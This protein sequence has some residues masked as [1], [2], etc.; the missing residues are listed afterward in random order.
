MSHVYHVTHMKMSH[1]YVYRCL[2]TMWDIS[3]AY[4]RLESH[5][6]FTWLHSCVWHDRHDSFTWMSH[7]YVSIDVRH[8][9]GV[10]PHQTA[11]RRAPCRRL[12]CSVNIYIC[13]EYVYVRRFISRRW[14]ASHLFWV[15]VCE[16][17]L[18]TQNK[19]MCIWGIFSYSEQM[20][21]I[22]EKMPH[23]HIPH[24]LYSFSDASHTHTL[25]STFV[26]SMC[27]WGI[28]ATWSRTRCI[29]PFVSD[30]YIYIYMYIYI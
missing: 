7:V 20:W 3:A 5:N 11:D 9:S 30:K 19:S 10:Y 16:A 1:I 18:H 2:T 6:S 13:S 28:S 14:N 15:C 12:R 8:I 17:F 21:G 24:I 29:R 22:T 27:M 4:T 23:I 25:L 26:L